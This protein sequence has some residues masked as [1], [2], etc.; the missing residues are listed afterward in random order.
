MRRIS[1]N[2]ISW[3]T[4]E[5]LFLQLKAEQYPFKY[6]IGLTYGRAISLA[7]NLNKCQVQWEQDTGVPQGFAQRSAKAKLTEP[8]LPGLPVDYNAPAFV[9]IS[10]S[11]KR[12]GQRGDPT[13]QAILEQA[14]QNLKT[15]LPVEPELTVDL[16][17]ETQ[18]HTRAMACE[19]R[20]F[21]KW[22]KQPSEEAEHP[23]EPK[24]D[25]QTPLPSIPV[26]YVQVGS[27]LRNGTELIKALREGL[28]LSGGVTEE[29]VTEALQNGTQIVRARHNT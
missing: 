10:L 25:A 16:C 8:P 4:F 13:N 11:P 9:E 18:R 24:A 12:T 2:T 6:D 3:R 17:P 19:T 15:Q 28:N 14:L 5:V 29:D 27:G 22:F 23:P 7:Q 1:R 26:G 20:A 21:D